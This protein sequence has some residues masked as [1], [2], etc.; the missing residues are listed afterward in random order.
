MFHREIEEY[1]Q[2]LRLNIT[3]ERLIESVDDMIWVIEKEDTPES[4]Y[5]VFEK[6]CYEKICKDFWLIRN[7][8]DS[9]IYE[10]PNCENSEHLLWN[11]KN[12]KLWYIYPKGNEQYSKRLHTIG[13]IRFIRWKQ[14]WRIV[15]SEGNLRF[16]KNI[17]VSEWWSEITISSW[18]IYIFYGDYP[19][20]LYELD[21][22]ESF[23]IHTWF[24]KKYNLNENERLVKG[25]WWYL[26][27]NGEHRES[28][29]V[30]SSWVI[31][32]LVQFSNWIDRIPNR[33]VRAKEKLYSTLIW[34]A[35]Q[36]IFEFPF[37]KKMRYMLSVGASMIPILRDYNTDVIENFD[38]IYDST[39]AFV[40]WSALMED[41]LSDSLVSKQDFE[42]HASINEIL[43]YIEVSQFGD[44]KDSSDKF[45]EE[46]LQKEQILK[47][48]MKIWLLKR[49]EY[50]RQISRNNIWFTFGDEVEYLY[51][52]GNFFEVL[53]LDIWSSLP[54]FN[55]YIVK[56]V[57][58]DECKVVSK[59]WFKKQVVASFDVPHKKNVDVWEHAKIM[60]VELESLDID[61]NVTYSMK[62]D[63]WEC[64]FKLVDN[65]IQT[66]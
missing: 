25:N 36:L 20:K 3:V 66:I 4:K 28:R 46:Y 57:K 55:M 59:Y 44:D 16:V 41:L 6:E 7:I 34:K 31:R 22:W 10:L 43:W 53:L 11:W 8:K 26:A 23:V 40:S 9:G 49:L 35:S 19:E 58:T 2:V 56:S 32:T 65:K 30:S 29:E 33:I 48:I 47:I 61:E 63:S 14:E 13:N 17:R 27:I 39:E 12:K 45:K 42:I 15:K 37:E 54:W 18:N 50:L 5:F 1:F 62:T 21:E 38:I 24:H 60:D 64:N 51:L 52:D